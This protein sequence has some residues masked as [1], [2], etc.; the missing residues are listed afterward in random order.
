MERN[1]LTF[2]L[3]A[4]NLRIVGFY[5][6]ISLVQDIILE[7]HYK[8]ST[9]FFYRFFEAIYN[10]VNEK[11]CRWDNKIAIELES[12]NRHSLVSSHLFVGFND[13][14]FSLGLSVFQPDFKTQEHNQIFTY[15]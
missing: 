13:S 9:T 2:L 11:G 6:Y 1:T 3:N 14:K 12:I 4:N 15:G 7:Q 8:D 10:K 5:P